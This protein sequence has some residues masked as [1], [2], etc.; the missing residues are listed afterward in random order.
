MRSLGEGNSRLEEDRVA[1]GDGACIFNLEKSRVRL[2]RPNSANMPTL[3]VA[4]LIRRVPLSLIHSQS[5]A[6]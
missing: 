3:C 2:R 6:A 4:M 1:I 5:T